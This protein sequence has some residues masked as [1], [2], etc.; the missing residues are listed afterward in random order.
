[1]S[2]FQIPLSTMQRIDSIRRRFLWRGNKPYHDGYSLVSWDNVCRSRC[3]GG[4]GVIN[5]RVLNCY[6]LYKWW[7]RFY[8]E[9][10]EILEEPHLNIHFPRIPPSQWAK[11]KKKKERKVSTSLRSIMKNANW[12]FESIVFFQQK[13]DQI[14]F[15]FDTWILKE[16]LKKI[17]SLYSS[18]Y[19]MNQESP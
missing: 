13:G 14:T 10:Q 8:I 19:L 5:I 17:A 9:P 4:L 2:I 15:W 1:M 6:L 11:E 7:W 16:L 18:D 12:F 3:L